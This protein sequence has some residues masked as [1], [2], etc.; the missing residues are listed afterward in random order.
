MF[1][2]P[3]LRNRPLQWPGRPSTHLEFSDS[4]EFR[5]RTWQHGEVLAHG[6]Q[7]VAFSFLF[8]LLVLIYTV[9][10]PPYSPQSLLGHI[11]VLGVHTLRVQY[12]LP[13]MDLSRKIVEALEASL[14]PS[15]KRILGSG[16]LAQDSDGHGY[17]DH[18]LLSPWGKVQP[19]QGQVGGGG[20]LEHGA[21]NG[22]PSWLGLRAVPAGDLEHCHNGWTTCN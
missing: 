5:A 12:W 15:G 8:P 17:L 10:I 1:Y 22:S 9:R 11:L 2:S 6:P 20:P 18:G 7:S 4:L 13:R 21:Q 3:T 16:Y 19:E 14:G